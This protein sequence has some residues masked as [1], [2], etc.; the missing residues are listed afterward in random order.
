MAD[1]LI[2]TRES[3]R[4]KVFEK[5]DE[6]FKLPSPSGT[7]LEVVRLCNNETSSL[8]EIAEVI[9]T[10]PA[11]SAEIIK[12]ANSAFLSTGIQVASIQKATVK[13]GMKTVVNL[14]LGFSLLSSNK[15]GNCR[16]FDYPLFWRTSL[17]EALAARELARLEKAFDPDELFV[18]ALLAHMGTLSLATIFPQ[19]Y[20]EML[21]QKR[22]TP[23]SF[24]R[25]R[26]DFGIDSAEFTL[27]L[28][29]KW[30][31]PAHFALAAGFHEF[32]GEV[33]LGTGKTHRSAVIMNIAH[34]IAQMCQSKKAQPELLHDVFSTAERYGME[35]PNFADIFATI[36]ES[37][38]S[39]GQLLEIATR[40]CYRYKEED[41]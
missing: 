33:D 9:Q 26:Q 12:Y 39:H 2:T 37:W 19:D 6:E 16:N 35:I 8:H 5:L 21:G 27:E 22:A 13:L 15:I 30:G 11:L 40:E 1:N 31:L 41:Y 3:N 7:A 17:A 10:D 32:L 38:H 34:T 20:A 28:F 36:V 24:A 29:L 4:K 23:V 25:E 14:S 18:C